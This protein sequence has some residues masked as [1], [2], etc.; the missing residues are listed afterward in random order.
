MT[1]RDGA[2]PSERWATPGSVLS[3]SPSEPSVL[4]DSSWPD[5]TDVAW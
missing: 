4:S 1:G 3:S 2:G 5:S